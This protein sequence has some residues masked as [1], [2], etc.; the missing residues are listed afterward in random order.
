VVAATL[1]A[2]LLLT[3]AG[4][5]W[6]FVARQRNAARQA[7]VPAAEAAWVAR[8]TANAERWVNDL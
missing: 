3:A 1:V 2:L 7:E 6:Y 5:G 8:E 4:G